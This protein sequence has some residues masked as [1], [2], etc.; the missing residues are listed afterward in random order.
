MDDDENNDGENIAWILTT[1]VAWAYKWMVHFVL[2]D[3]LQTLSLRRT[4]IRCCIVYRQNSDGFQTVTMN[5][6]HIDVNYH[7]NLYFSL[8]LR[9][10]HQRKSIMS[11]TQYALPL[12]DLKALLL[13]FVIVI[14]RKKNYHLI[15][16]V[17]AYMSQWIE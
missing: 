11:H 14:F 13:F 2:L 9:S 3:G 17:D 8:E 4:A 12:S 16:A 15:E 10:H 6:N 5:R 7:S 1:A